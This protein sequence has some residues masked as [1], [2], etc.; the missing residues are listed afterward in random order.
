MS[1]VSLKLRSICYVARFQQQRRQAPCARLAI[2][3]SK[4]SPFI[5]ARELDL[6]IRIQPFNSV[7]YD[8]ELQPEPPK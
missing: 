5:G 1:K 8:Q 2:H 6:E 3:F 4:N 7:L